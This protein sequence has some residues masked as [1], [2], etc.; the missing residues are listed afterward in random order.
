MSTDL[1]DP[2]TEGGLRHIPFF[3]GRVLTAEDLQ[4]EQVAH[5]TERERLGRALGTGVLH[6][7]SVQR[8]SDTTVTVQS[9]QGLAPSG[10]VVE[11]PQKTEVSVVSG[12]EQEATAGTT[13]AFADCASRD[14]TVNA[15]SGAYILVA[16]PASETRGQTPRVGLGGDGAARGAAGECGA[17]HRVEG[18]K[19]RL[20]L[21]DPNDGALV[22]P[23]LAD[24]EAPIDV[25][26]LFEEIV[27]ARENGHEPAPEAVSVLRN[28]LAHVCL[29]TP[30]A[31]GVTATL[32][33]TLRRQAQGPETAAPPVDADGP[34]DVL[35]RRARTR[36][37]AEDLEDAIPLGLLC[38]AHDRLEFVDM[39]SVRRRVHRVAPERPMPATARRRAET[40]AAI[41]QFQAHVAD[42]VQRLGLQ[43]RIQARAADLFRFLPP[44][45]TVPGE[46]GDQDGF[47]L[48][49]FFEGL[50]ARE[51]LFVE[52]RELR[53]LMAEATRVD[54]SRVDPDLLVWRYLVRE[55]V[56]SAAG[57]DPSFVV[58]TSGFVPHAAEPQYNR[59]RWGYAT[60]GPAVA[61]R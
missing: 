52:G 3:N 10:R 54:A 58:F 17:K 20:V 29:R 37:E 35:R 23:S 1:D 34:V 40:E 51:P 16:E 19:L 59:S 50:A 36:D 57:E 28:T 43:G 4:T 12:T 26:G 41:F 15:G 49:A 9:G 21:F 55:D 38:W 8:A 7:L 42:L 46:R 31:T 33:D 6:G 2:I 22:P 39:W 45:G 14:L 47:D 30:S 44:V 27:G 32:Y 48:Y 56:Q 60:Y 61:V 11:L 24:G 18:A 25:E 53:S 5:A 13:G